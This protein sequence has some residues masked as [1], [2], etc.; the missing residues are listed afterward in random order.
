MNEF[1][2]DPYA[3]KKKW[4]NPT[5]DRANSYLPY[6]HHQRDPNKTCEPIYIE[7]YSTPASTTLAM[8]SILQDNITDIMP[9]PQ[10]QQQQQDHFTDKFVNLSAER[11]KLKTICGLR[12]RSVLFIS[13]IFIAIVV[14]IWYFVW[15]RIPNLALDDVDNVGTIQVLTSSTKKS[16]STQWSLNMTADNTANW[17]PTRINSIDILITDER[18]Q[19]SFGSGN[20]GWIILPPKQKSMIPIL[21]DIYYESYNVNDTTFQDLYNAC[22]VQVNSNTPFE[23]RQGVLNVTLSVTYHISGIVW[24]TTKQMHINSLICPTS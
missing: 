20:S 1:Q 13:L 12:Y 11:R 6:S 7:E 21:L 17:V 23:S 4:K 24:P 22:G 15:P 10:I 18:T 19:Q 2:Q 16:M 14:V 8:G 3:S 5:E 9:Q